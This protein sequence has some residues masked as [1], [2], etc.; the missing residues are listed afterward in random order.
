MFCLFRAE[1]IDST[2]NA[3]YIRRLALVIVAITKLRQSMI[4]RCSF[5]FNKN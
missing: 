3:K 2:L 1:V 5:T 4:S